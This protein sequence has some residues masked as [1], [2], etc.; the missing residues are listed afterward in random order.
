M[1]IRRPI[2]LPPHP[3]PS[4]SQP[5]LL[6]EEQVSIPRLKTSSQVWRPDPTSHVFG[7]AGGVVVV[8]AMVVEVVV[9]VVVVVAPQR[10]LWD[11]KANMHCKF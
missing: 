1:L 8:V 9:V 6:S 7:H 2:Y 10:H 4:H 3:Y 5:C 11:R